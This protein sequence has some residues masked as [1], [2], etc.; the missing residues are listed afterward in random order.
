MAN[1]IEERAGNLMP[2]WTFWGV[3]VVL[4]SKD[5]WLKSKRKIESLLRQV[6]RSKKQ[7]TELRKGVK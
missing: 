4:V 7:I 6:H 3:G 2:V 1:T 5:N